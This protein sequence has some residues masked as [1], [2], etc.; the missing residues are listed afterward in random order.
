[1]FIATETVKFHMHNILVKYK[2]KSRT[3][4]QQRLKEWDFSAWEPPN[5]NPPP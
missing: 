1:M 3:Q 4:L 5:N 2:L